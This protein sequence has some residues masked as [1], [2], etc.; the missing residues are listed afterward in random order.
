MEKGNQMKVQIIGGSGTGKST[1]AKFISE[2]EN[3]MWIDTDR[4]LWKDETFTENH[5]IEKRIEMYEKDIESNDQ[6]VVSGSVFSWN[7][8][9][10]SNRNLFVFLY[11]DEEI[12]MERLRKRE[13][14]RDNPKKTWT[15]EYGNNTNE[16]LEWCKTYLKEKDKTMIGTYAAQSYEMELSKSPV[17]KLDSSRSVEELYL[18]IKAWTKVDSKIT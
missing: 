4:Y 11:L 7:P 6:Y 17:L 13:I 14:R 16:F 2:N 15:D 5:S 10:F 8:N 3:I 1:L 9:G 18:A 12:R